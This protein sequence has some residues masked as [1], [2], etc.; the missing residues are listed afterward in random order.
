MSLRSLQKL[1][2]FSQKREEKCEL[3]AIPLAEEHQH[4]L[5]PKKREAICA[6]D[7][8]ALLFD[9]T[10]KLKRIPRDARSL[11]DFSFPE[12]KWKALVP[13]KLAFVYRKSEEKEWIAIFPSPA[14][15]TES[16]L[17]EWEEFES[18]HPLL[19][20]MEPDVEALLVSRL[21]KKPEYLVAPM[22]RCFALVGLLRRNWEGIN[23]G[24]KVWPEV[25]RY[26]EQLKRRAV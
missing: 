9:G 21:G 7:A 25:H 26:L 17:G 10:T 15:V 16:V 8:C 2:A 3:C 14:G 4:L 24:D 1:K 11:P 18:L 6:C 23:G 19:K 12:E 22:D 5:D 13:V 20:E